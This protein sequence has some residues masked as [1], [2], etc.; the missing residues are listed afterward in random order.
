MEKNLHEQ[1]LVEQEQEIRQQQIEFNEKRRSIERHFD[2][3]IESIDLK[4]RINM[5]S[6][7]LRDKSRSIHQLDESSFVVDFLVDRH[8]STSPFSVPRNLTKSA[9]F[10]ARMKLLEESYRRE[11]RNLIVQREK[12]LGKVELDELKLRYEL[13]RKKTKD[14]YSMFYGMLNDQ[15]DKE[16][17]RFDEQCRLDKQETLR[18]LVDEL[19]RWSNSWNKIQQIRSIRSTN[20]EQKFVESGKVR[21]VEIDFSRRTLF[22]LFVSERE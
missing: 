22:R 2:S 16:L 20:N 18:R 5:K 9:D 13:L 6:E 12:S 11:R 4:Y 8:E 7:Y 3:E 17:K 15:L 10:R 14:Y 19:N 1:L 21:R